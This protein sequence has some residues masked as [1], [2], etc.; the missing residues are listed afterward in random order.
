MN[1]I[2]SRALALLI[3]VAIL[4]GGFFF[5]LLEYFTEGKNWVLFPGSP[6]IYNGENLGCGVVTDRDHILLLDMTDGRTYSES[7]F[8]R[9]ATVHWIGDR[10]GSVSAPA[11]SHYAGQIAG[12]DPANGIYSYGGAGG[13]VKLTLSSAMQ[14][15]ALEALDGRKG[16][17][18]VFNY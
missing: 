14:I 12:F 2:A 17:V 13:V 9:R 16:T 10:F 5:F 11:L 7:A 6:H 1:R 4:L 3:V 15:T 18:A 8:I